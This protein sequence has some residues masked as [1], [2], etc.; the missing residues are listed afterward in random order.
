MI[1]VA[2]EV[3]AVL[4]RLSLLPRSSRDPG[5]ILISS[6]VWTKFPPSPCD[7]VGT[8]PGP[9]APPHVPKTCGSSL[10]FSPLVQ[11][12]SWDVQQRLADLA[13]FAEISAVR[14]FLISWSLLPSGGQINNHRYLLWN[15]IFKNVW[16]SS[17]ASTSISNSACTSG[18]THFP[19]VSAGQTLNSGIRGMSHEEAMR[20]TGLNSLEEDKEIWHVR[21]DTHQL[22]S[23]HHGKHPIWMH[24]GLVWQLLC[25]GLQ[26]TA[27]SRGHSPAHHGNQPPLHGLCLHFLLPR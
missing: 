15:Q 12:R 7:L 4:Q 21:F 1:H 3:L 24:R 2:V 19:G 20:K 8:L 5:S 10:C 25:P 13:L 18:G 16:K 11:E 23:M 6:A 26:E 17:R 14:C 27:E 22:L 9:P